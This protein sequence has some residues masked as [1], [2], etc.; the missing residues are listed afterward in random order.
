MIQVQGFYPS[1]AVLM[2]VS[3]NTANSSPA[4]T[5]LGA[6]V[7]KSAIAGIGATAQVSDFDTM[8]IYKDIKLCN[9]AANGTVNA[10]LGDAGFKRD[11]TNGDVM[12]EIPA[13][14]YKI[15]PGTVEEWWIA[16]APATGFA[17]HPAFSRGA[18]L[19]DVRKIYI[20][21][22]E[23]ASGHASKSGVAPLNG[24]SRAAVRSGVAA[25]GAGWAQIDV[26]A[27]SA[28]QLLMCVEYA[29][30]DSQNTIGGGISTTMVS[31]QVTGTTDSMAGHTGRPSHALTTYV[32]V[33]WRGLE[34]L[35]GNYLGL[36]DGININGG[37]YYYCLNPNNFADDTAAGY[38]YAGYSVPTELSADRT[39]TMGYNAGCPWFRLPIAGGGSDTTYY[40]DA[41]Y[42]ATG[43]RIAYNGGMQGMEYAAGAFNWA[44]DDASSVAAAV[45]G[46]RIM[47]YQ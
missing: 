24:L 46:S 39:K 42:T 29:N 2:G 6:A 47:R 28:V 32:G 9:L 41:V 1:L 45:V 33:K 18:P 37:A 13:F 35:W 30:L 36:V 34:N 11:G 23:S 17:K 19:S 7:G 20:G 26:A 3:H 21:A 15:V 38:T 43:W 10:Y 16:S 25:K 22:Y 44:L 8:P 5:R 31:K 14:W 4:L 40:C 27:L 12:V